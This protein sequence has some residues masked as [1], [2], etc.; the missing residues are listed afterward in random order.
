[1]TRSCASDVTQCSAARV[2]LPRNY[3]GRREAAVVWSKRQM[4]ASTAVA[5]SQRTRQSHES[6]CSQIVAPNEGGVRAGTKF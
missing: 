1:M 6:S 3:L 4:F 5:M 2:T